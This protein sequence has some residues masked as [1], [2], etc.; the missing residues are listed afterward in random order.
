MRTYL[1]SLV[2][3]F[4]PIIA[5]DSLTV[6]PTTTC[7][8]GSCEIHIRNT[9]PHGSAFGTIMLVS[10][11]PVSFQT[12]S[13]SNLQNG[14]TSAIS[15]LT[16]AAGWTILECDENTIAQDIRA[17]CTGEDNDCNHIYLNG[18]VG[19]IVRLPDKVLHSRYPIFEERLLMQG[20]IVWQDAIRP[21]ILRVGS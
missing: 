3:L 2:L 20:F 5:A 4:P 8:H 12:R 7:I 15:D 1:F 18:A 16:P 13:R 19:T 17:V 6:D 11:S 21:G 14:S 9:S 10:I